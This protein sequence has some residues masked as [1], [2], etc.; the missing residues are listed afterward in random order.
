M[1]CTNFYTMKVGEL[2]DGK[3]T[4][5][6]ATISAMDVA[7]LAHALFKTLDYIYNDLN[8]PHKEPVEDIEDETKKFAV[9]VTHGKLH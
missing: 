9:F 8:M 7:A 5:R 3:L 1:V 4:R 2:L 6:H